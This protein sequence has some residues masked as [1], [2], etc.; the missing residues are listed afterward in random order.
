MEKPFYAGKKL[1]ILGGGQLGRMLIQAAIDYDVH[2]SILDPNPQAPCHAYAHTFTTGSLTDYDTVMAFGA[3]LDLLTIEIENVN[4]EALEALQAQGKEVF[5]DPKTVRM[6]QDKRE[7]KQF[8]ARHDLPTSP[9][10][11]T[12]NRAAV[13]AE[14][15]RMPLVQ[16]LG[17][18]GYDG[19]GV[20]VLKN[21]AD[22]AEAFDAPSLLEDFVPFEKEI[23]V[24]V[25]RNPQGETAVFPTV[26]MV[27]DPVLNLVDYLFAPA[28]LSQ[29]QVEAATAI[30]LRL[31]DKLDYVGLLAV[32]MFALKDGQIW[33][34]EIAPRPHNSGHFSIKACGTSQYEQHLRA[35][36]GLPMGD[37]RLL[38][39]AAMVNLL[40]A[41]DHRG[42][43]RYEGIEDILAI[44]GVY[45]HLYGK[46]ET[47]PGRKMGHVTIL[48][49]DLPALTQKIEQV[50]SSIQ[51]KSLP[52]AP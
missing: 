17:K 5:P 3:D 47:K 42:P 34:N 19:R 40:G 23:A 46:S 48:G 26:E 15:A 33:I 21:E 18:A 51:V 37:T 10:V 27:F 29:A 36:L 43:A 31:V 4:T 38:S 25:A 24:I 28:Q 6:I 2:I 14:K 13:L 16:K 1:G 50:K 9:F 39:P 30:A 8:Y 20:K 12:D 52:A 44:P 45:P 41:P 11:L 35:I 7:Q 32:E 22:L 49:E